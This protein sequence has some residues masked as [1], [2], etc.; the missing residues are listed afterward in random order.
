MTC[1]GLNGNRRRPQKRTRE[2]VLAEGRD[3]NQRIID[4]FRENGGKIGGPFEGAPLLLLHST[5]ARSGKIRVNPMMYQCVRDA[6]AVFAS[7]AGADTNPDWFHNLVAN[8]EAS[9]EVGT[10][11][12]DVTARVAEGSERERIWTKQKRNYPG[13][14]DYEKGASR[15][16][17]VVILERRNG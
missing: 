1:S 6:Y 2:A 17:P 9:V 10:E 12:F 8:P 4:E 15:Q 16:I 14:A 13:F 7:K 11:T 3:W 5:G